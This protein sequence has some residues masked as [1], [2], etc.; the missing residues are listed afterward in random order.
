[1]VYENPNNSVFIINVVTVFYLFTFQVI[2]PPKRRIV[3]LY[4]LFQLFI[5]SIK[6]AFIIISNSSFPPNLNFNIR[7]LNK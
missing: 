2:N 1:M 7:V 3:Y 6:E 5:S 4:K